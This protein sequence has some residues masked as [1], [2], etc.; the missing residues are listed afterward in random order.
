M[1]QPVSLQPRRPFL[2]MNQHHV[3]KFVNP[4]RALESIQGYAFENGRFRENAYIIDINCR[5]F[6]LVGAV[7][8]GWHRHWATLLS[9][10][11]YPPAKRFYKFDFIVG[12]PQPLSFEEAREEIVE[13]IC[14]KGWF[15]KTE[16]RE[17]QRQ[18]RERMEMCENMH[19]LIMG[20][21]NAD[22]KSKKRF[23]WIGGIH[24]YGE[25]V[26]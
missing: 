9:N 3:T 5:K 17:S 15:S 7:K 26:F 6:P 19:D 23:H 2:V 25:S 20:R 14:A 22:P 4:P 16:D 18:F 8:K 11:F 12:E 24:G 10:L 21:P 1:T 13:L